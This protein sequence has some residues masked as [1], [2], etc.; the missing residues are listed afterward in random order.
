MSPKIRSRRHSVATSF[1]RLEFARS[2]RAAV[3]WLAWLALA[4]SLALYAEL[5]WILRLGVAFLVVVVGGWTV[6][7]F[8]LQSGPRALRALEWSPDDGD[9]YYVCVGP[10]GRR[11]PAIPADCRRYGPVLWL[12][13]FDTSE[14]RFQLLV[15]PV[16]Q[17]PKA[18]RRLGRRL[19]GVPDRRIGRR[20]GRAT[21][22]S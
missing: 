16:I 2:R 7:S 12:L 14:G 5:S 21:T 6:R 20:S 15:E 1:D 8:I 3:A 22:G 17:E 9:S 19:F 4:A 10:E 11:L 13:R 18:L